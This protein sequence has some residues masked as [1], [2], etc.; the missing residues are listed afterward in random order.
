MKKV[1]IILVLIISLVTISSA[2][3]AWNDSVSTVVTAHSAVTR[4]NYVGRNNPSGV[5]YTQQGGAVSTSN[6]YFDIEE[7]I[8]DL[9]PN[10]SSGDYTV[11]YTIQNTGTVPVSFDGITVG[12][13]IYYSTSYT[14]NWSFY[15]QM[16]L[17]SA[18]MQY[19]LAINS[20]SYTYTQTNIYNHPGEF[21]AFDSV[22]NVLQPDETCTLTVRYY[23]TN[24]MS[25]YSLSLWKDETI[26]YSLYH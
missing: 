10:S 20:T 11:V 18:R 5:A 15:N 25:S 24:S 6:P 13:T 16:I 12:N 17:Y 22:D 19:T 4:L 8:I 7:N 3:A 1:I 23:R 14:G 26:N 9:Y 2:Y 21:I